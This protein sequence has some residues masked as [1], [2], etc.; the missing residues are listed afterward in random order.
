[1]D[2]PKE[3]LEQLVESIKQ[4]AERPAPQPSSFDSS[5]AADRIR[6]RVAFGYQV[7]GTLTGRVSSPSGNE[8]DV[9]VVEAWR[10]SEGIQ[11]RGLPPGADWV[12]LRAGNKVEVLRIQRYEDDSQIDQTTTS[13]ET[14]R[15]EQSD[16]RN[17]QSDKGQVRPRD[18]KDADPI[19]SVVFLR[20][21]RGPLIAFGPRLGPVSSRRTDLDRVT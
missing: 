4:L 6:Q 9:R 3:L 5:T 1:M 14:A 7:L 17:E 15:N 19:G 13:K 8:F 11:F 20:T 10:T 16:T 2:T 12:E 21:R 18:F